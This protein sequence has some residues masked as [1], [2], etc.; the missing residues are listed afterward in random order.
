M[1][2]GE[3]SSKWFEEESCSQIYTVR[4]CDGGGF[5]VAVEVSYLSHLRDCRLP[6]DVDY[7]P[8]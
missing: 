2:T 6:V 1:P 3:L 5:E 7:D 8:M 4:K